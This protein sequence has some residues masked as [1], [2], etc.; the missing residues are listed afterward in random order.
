MREFWRLGRVWGKMVRILVLLEWKF[1]WG[2]GERGI[3]G[4]KNEI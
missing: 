4:K 3:K 2:I 1:Y